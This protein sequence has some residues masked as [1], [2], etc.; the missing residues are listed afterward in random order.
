M[1]A[2]RILGKNPVQWFYASLRRYG[3]GQTIAIM[4]SVMVDAGFDYRYGTDTARRIPRSE[5]ETNS[6]NIVHCVNYGASKEM[7]F[8]KLM[9]RLNLP[10]DGVFV[11]LGSGKGR[12]LM[13]AAKYGFRKV[14]GVEF[15]G[16]LCTAARENLQKFLHKC[17]SRS[18]VEVIESDVTKYAF[19]DDETV[20]FM[21]DPF[22]APVL[23]Q[24]LQNI[25]VSVERSPRTIW[26]IYSVPREQ[27]IIDQAGLFKHNELHVVVGAEFRVY[28]NESSGRN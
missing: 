27:H 16:A 15:S 26:L 13:L 17:P 10:K 12:A 23:T 7:P 2:I 20:F 11:D 18:H 4:W 25:R 19:H 9:S 1:S 28:S 22:N 6:E 14:I 24:V 21:L 8:R 3:L 5:I